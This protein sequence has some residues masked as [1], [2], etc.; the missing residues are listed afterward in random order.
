MMMYVSLW[1]FTGEVHNLSADQNI[2]LKFR[3]V[4]GLGVRF[5]A[6]KMSHD[7]LTQAVLLFVKGWL[8]TFRASAQG[9]AW[10]YL[11]AKL[12]DTIIV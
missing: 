11:S 7:I 5:R 12:V 2:C 4:S 8:R 10:V 6:R 9:W 1:C 3:V